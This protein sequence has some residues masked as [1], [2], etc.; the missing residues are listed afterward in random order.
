[1]MPSSMIP[2]AQRDDAELVAASLAGDRDAFGQIVSRY[3]ALICSLAYNATGSIRQSED[4]A[5]ETFLNAWLGLGQLRET[6]KLR[7]WLCGIVRHKISGALASAGREPSHAA[8]PLD[9]MNEPAAS[10]ALPSEQAVSRE[11]QAILWRSLEQIPDIYRETLILFYRENQS[12]E[13]VAASLELSQDA[14]KQRLSRGRK[15]LQEQVAAFVEGALRDTAPG[16]AFT[17][18]VLGVLP[19][20]T[21]PAASAAGAAAKGAAAAK[22]AALAPLVVAIAGP[23][24]GILG[25][26]L[27]YKINMEN[28]GS[29]RERQFLEK[30]FR[31]VF[32][33]ACLFT[34]GISAFVTFSVFGSPAHP[35]LVIV[36][37][38]LLIFTYCAGLI[39]LITRS[40]RVQRLIRLEEAAKRPPHSPPFVRPWRTKPF[41]YRSRRTLFGLPLVHI[42]MECTR[43]GRILPAVG[44]IA[45]GNI[46]YGVLFAF[47]GIS[48]GAM[49][50]GGASVGLLAVGG[51]GVGMVSFAGVALGVWAAGGI[52]AG[53]MAFGGGAAGWLAASG[54]VAAAH[55][56]AV[57]APAAAQHANDAAAQAF[58]A[59]STFFH[60]ARQVSRC[61]S[62]LIWLPMALIVWQL[63]RFRRNSRS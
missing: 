27:G 17:F 26:W 35:L 55:E 23:V 19:A 2:A 40:N 8:E 15:L 14:V 63:T 12:V 16:R 45:V 24:V 43:D 38:A 21:L 53:Y 1:M 57:G 13:S 33:M 54:G 37:V 5:Q 9:T 11:E 48:V 58:A 47:G 44:W 22:S 7:A 59:D 29:P 46:A 51:V 3:Q 28:A 32:V 49:S 10:E 50:I 42:S 18:G 25:G 20:L 60:C 6:S 30:T 4:L 34:L 62:I 56:F 31:L 39:A 41:E 61:V 36:G 52:S